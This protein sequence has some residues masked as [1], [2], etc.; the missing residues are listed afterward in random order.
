[1]T[2]TRQVSARAGLGPW[3]REEGG[4][5][6]ARP[7]NITGRSTPSWPVHFSRKKP[8]VKAHR[9]GLVAGLF[10]IFLKLWEESS[11]R[12][13]VNLA[14]REVTKRMQGVGQDRLLVGQ[15]RLHMGQ[16]RLH[17]FSH[18]QP[19]NQQVRD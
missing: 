1:M 10:Q 3:G 18:H 9:S 12:G 17:G 2:P 4:V 16:D 14:R 19:Y 7:T 15:D 11:G 6:R 13:G 5:S 8:K